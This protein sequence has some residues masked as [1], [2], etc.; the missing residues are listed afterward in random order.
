MGWGNVAIRICV[1][2]Q[3]LMHSEKN[4][5]FRYISFSFLLSLSEQ[6]WK[7]KVKI[8]TICYGVIIWDLC[9]LLF[10][11]LFK[12]SSAFCKLRARFIDLNPPSLAL[13]FLFLWLIQW[14]PSSARVLNWLAA[15]ISW[16]ATYF[17]FLQFPFSFIMNIISI[18][19]I[20]IRSVKVVKVYIFLLLF[21]YQKFSC[22]CSKSSSNNICKVESP[23]KLPSAEGRFCTVEQG[24]R[25]TW[26]YA[27][28]PTFLV[29]NILFS[30][31]NLTL[32]ASDFSHFHRVSLHSVIIRDFHSR[33]L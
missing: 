5:C 33:I 10:L 18:L 19:N 4:E 25:Y 14:I 21:C 15:C 12:I 6:R 7:R 22:H 8:S 1:L 13:N 23:E 17:N 30:V 27:I 2:Y 31:S 20:F 26:N 3:P 11:K 28:Y 29:L 9:I 32:S 16:V 24:M